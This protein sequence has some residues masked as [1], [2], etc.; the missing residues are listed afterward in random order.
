MV[1]VESLI[2]AKITYLK[3]FTR[4]YK[5]RTSGY[6]DKGSALVLF[7]TQNILRIVSTS[8]QKTTQLARTCSK[9]CF[10]ECKAG[11]NPIYTESQTI[12]VKPKLRAKTI[13]EIGHVNPDNRVSLGACSTKIVGKLAANCLRH[14]MSNTKFVKFSNRFQ[15]FWTPHSEHQ[16]A[17]T[18]CWTCFNML[19]QCSTSG[20]KMRKNKWNNKSY[21]INQWLL[22]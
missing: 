2:V 7:T 12:R 1:W 18:T 21:G 10:S 14:S 8:A 15:E 6:F 17:C 4:P 22:K 19:Q 13:R 20:L 16:K 5:W 11:R 9:W 3:F